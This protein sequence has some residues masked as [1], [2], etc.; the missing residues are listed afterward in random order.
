MDMGN[1]YEYRNQ[2]R[3]LYDNDVYK[4]GD[5]CSNVLQIRDKNK[6]ISA[7]SVSMS[8]YNIS[9]QFEDNVDEKKKDKIIDKVKDAIHEY[10]QNNYSSLS[11]GN[12]GKKAEF[13]KLINMESSPYCDIVLVGNS[14]SFNL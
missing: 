1:Y 11:F 14:V 2:I 9:M 4:S 6:C 5:L 8:D 7:V 12:P 3:S 13:E 10:I